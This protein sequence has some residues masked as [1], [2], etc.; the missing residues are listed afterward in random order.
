[1][2]KHI[3]WDLDGTLFET[4][5]AISNAILASLVDHGFH[6][7]PDIVR[8]LAKVSAS[9]CIA[10]LAET[11]R[12]ASREI[13][14][15]FYYHYG[16][17][18]YFEQPIKPGAFE[19]CS[20]I[21]THG[22]H[23]LIITHRGNRSTKELLRYHG[24]NALISDFIT[25]D[26]GFPKKPDPESLL[27]ILKRNQLEASEAV[28]IGDQKI[29]VIAGQAAG[30]RTCILGQEDPKTQADFQ[31]NSFYELIEII[32]Q[33]NSNGKEKTVLNYGDNSYEN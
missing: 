25:G 24:L 9:H 22:G 18:P 10:I 21:H 28:T 19:L 31:V 1:M 32:Q 13:H 30:L 5:P 15:G 14:E 17:I 7:K 2:I 27:A 6:P 26:D 16:E 20:Y 12:I 3:L 33:E 4:N 23:N 11:L 29:D 8:E